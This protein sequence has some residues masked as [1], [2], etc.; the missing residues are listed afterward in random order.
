MAEQKNQ[1]SEKEIVINAENGILGRIASLAAK[2]ALQGHKVVIVNS[3]K[4][5]ITGNKKNI[6]ENYRLKIA[7][8]IGSLKG[9]Y[10]PKVPENIMKR[11]VRGMLKYKRGR[12]NEAFQN[13]ICFK[14]IPP[15]Y[16]SVKKIEF[17]SKDIK[18]MTLEEVSKLS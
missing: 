11:T 6:L 18:S 3:E 17:E 12:G 9:P 10:F 5:I 8:G 2:Q 14:G 16:V 15:Q 4:S 13:V 1:K 7:R